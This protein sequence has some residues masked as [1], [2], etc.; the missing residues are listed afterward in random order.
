MASA[1][2]AAACPSQ[3]S[4]ELLRSMGEALDW[5]SPLRFRCRRRVQRI[6]G[7]DYVSPCIDLSRTAL[8]FVSYRATKLSIAF[9]TFRKSP[10]LLSLSLIMMNLVVLAGHCQLTS[11]HSQIISLYFSLAL[12][13]RFTYGQNLHKPLPSDI[14]SK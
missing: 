9:W 1:T 3:T 11:P 4:T 12:S 10:F 2:L 7:H 6:T 5:Q 8:S 13:R 14:S